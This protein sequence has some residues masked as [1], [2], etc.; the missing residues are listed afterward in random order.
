MAAFS[1]PDYQQAAIIYGYREA[2]NVGYV[3]TRGFNVNDSNVTVRPAV[4]VDLGQVLFVSPAVGGKPDLSDPSYRIVTNDDGKP[5]MSPVSD[6]NGSD[7]KLTV[8]DSS[9][10]NFYAD[11]RAFKNG[12]CKIGYAKAKSTEKDVI[13]GMIVDADGNVKY[14]GVLGYA[15][16]AILTQVPFDV[17]G[18]YEVGDRIYIFNEEINGDKQT[19]YSSALIDITPEKLPEGITATVGQRLADV[20]IPNPDGNTSGTWTWDAATTYLDTAGEHTFAATFTPS[21]TT[22]FDIVNTNLTVTVG[23]GTPDYARR[24]DAEQPVREHARHVDLGRSDDVRRQ[25]GQRRQKLPGD[26]HTGRH[27]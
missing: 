17:S 6:Y 13:S 15:G 2:S 19:D 23:K 7:W 14:Y 27:G 16:G 12:T 22:A 20:A 5:I 4:N 18:Q 26:L 11:C 3:S 21:N 9:R 10:S 24:R 25:R 8:L 1:R